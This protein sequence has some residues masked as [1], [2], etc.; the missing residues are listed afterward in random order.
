[1]I[2]REF[3]L[4]YVFEDFGKLKEG[5]EFNSPEEEHFG[6]KWGVTM[7]KDDDVLGIFLHPIFN[8]NQEIGVDH[9]IKLISKKKNKTCPWSASCVFKYQEFRG[10]YH[11][12]DWTS[13]EN[14]YL[15]DGKLEMEVH[16]RITKIKE[17]P[18]GTDGSLIELRSFGEDMEQFSDVIL[19]V[20]ERKFHVLKLYLSS[21]SPYF[22]TLFLGQFQES[23]KSEIE[24]KDIDHQDFQYYLE[25]LYGENRIDDQT[26]QGILSVA[27]MYDTPLTVKK[28]EEFLVERSKLELK[29]EARIG[30]K[31]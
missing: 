14:D 6:V 23:E 12:I 24:L 20:N 4:K 2:K 28:C 25:V 26:V 19:K 21:H 17:I 10:C 16:V 5:E 3:T 31:L 22:A 27:D 11:F 13:V 9:T 7:E 18:E 8:E 15:D 29:K 30:W 1:M